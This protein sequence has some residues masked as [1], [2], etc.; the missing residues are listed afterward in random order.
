MVFLELLDLRDGLLTDLVELVGNVIAADLFDPA[1]PIPMLLVW[2]PVD[3][4][5]VLTPA[6]VE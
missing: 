3:L 4:D 1:T 6:D 5:P 2:V